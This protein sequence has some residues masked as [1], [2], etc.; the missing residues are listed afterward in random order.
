[1]RT[2]VFAAATFA[3]SASATLAAPPEF[4]ERYARDAVHEFRADTHIPLC[5]R[6]E[7]AR[8]HDNF[9]V[10]FNWCLHVSID[11]ADSERDY[12]RA[13]LHECRARLHY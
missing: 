11:Q 8:W 13:R 5:F 10:H 1:M 2:L 12:R 3:L 9:D 6:G 4:C 7:N